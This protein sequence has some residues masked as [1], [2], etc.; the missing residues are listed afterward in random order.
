MFHTNLSIHIIF[1]LPFSLPLLLSLSLSFW[2]S[3]CHYFAFLYSTDS[4]IV[5][6]IYNTIATYQTHNFEIIIIH[7]FF[8][9]LLQVR[10]RAL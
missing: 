1:L 3:F 9:D 5:F 4:E 7:V 2:P 8:Y 10:S 6:S